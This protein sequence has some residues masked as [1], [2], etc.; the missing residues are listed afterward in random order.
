M[1]KLVVRGIVSILLI[2]FAVSLFTGIG[3]FLAPSGKMARMTEWYLA[4][5]DK[6]KLE[7]MHAVSGF[8]MDVVAVIHL[9]LN[10][11]MLANKIKS[12]GKTSRGKG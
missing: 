10:I 6:W 7:N 11:G 4:G 9:M 12:F 3:L 2:P 5:M 1:K 8:A